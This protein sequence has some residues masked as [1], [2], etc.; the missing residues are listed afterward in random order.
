METNISTASTAFELKKE[1][2]KNYVDGICGRKFT[3]EEDLFLK[4]EIE[5]FGKGAWS[6]ILKCSLF[7]FQPN[8]TRYSLRMRA[9]T[10]AFKKIQSK[11]Y[12][13]N[14]NLFPTN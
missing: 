14:F 13:V 5:K 11:K 8:R 6:N 3:R 1:I 12:F 9:E 2:D 10:A 7:Q 4:Q